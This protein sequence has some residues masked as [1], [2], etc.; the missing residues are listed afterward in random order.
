MATLEAYRPF[1]YNE[2]SGINIGPGEIIS[3]V[4]SDA[5]NGIYEISGMVA[6]E[7]D[8]TSTNTDTL[9]PSITITAQ[10][11]ELPKLAIPLFSADNL[12]N[13]R[14]PTPISFNG[15][16]EV[17]DGTLTVNV[18]FYSTPFAIKGKV[19]YAFLKVERK[20]ESTTPE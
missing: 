19:K 5:P 15:V 12:A 3:I 7:Y 6:L 8:D 1:F 16:C 11:R 2:A 14:Q 9:T 17:T 18:S 13:G 4:E 20:L 10:T